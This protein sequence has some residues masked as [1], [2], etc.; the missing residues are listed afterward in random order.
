MN[1]GWLVHIVLRKKKLISV[2][3]L[4]STAVACWYSYSYV[5]PTYRKQTFFSFTFPEYSIGQKDIVSIRQDGLVSFCE[6]LNQVDAV[7][8]KNNIIKLS[9]V[10]SSSEELLRIEKK[11]VKKLLSYINSKEGNPLM[12]RKLAFENQLRA[13]ERLLEEIDEGA[14]KVSF[15]KRSTHVALQNVYVELYALYVVA[16]L[17]EEN[18]KIDL[19][20]LKPQGEVK[21][22]YGFNRGAFVVLSFFV[23]L[24]L[25]STCIL[26][27]AECKK[28]SFATTKL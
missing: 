2:V 9:W 12:Q 27:S 21:E 25:S 10:A 20:F 19:E 13:I 14:K 26:L 8:I 11:G 23:S 16:Q 6:K 5:K 4:I 22:V 17:N 28:C 3:V 7:T 15:K 18:S 24:I 1:F